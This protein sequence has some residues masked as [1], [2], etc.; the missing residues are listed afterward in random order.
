MIIETKRGELVRVA[1]PRDPWGAVTSL[2]IRTYSGQNVTPE[3]A[4]G[5]VAVMGAVS[6]V[7]DYN[8]AMPLETIDTRAKSGHKL[9]E[10]GWLAPMLRHAPN[11][12]Q[13]GPDLWVMVNAHLMLRGNAY[14]AKIRD[15]QGVIRE[16]YPIHPSCVNPYRDA[17]GRKLFRV[18]ISTGIDYTEADYTSDAI[19]HI[20]GKSINDP[21]VGESVIAHCRN[22]LGT[23]AAQVEYQARAYQD[24]MLIKGVLSTPERNL[25]PEAVERVKAQWRSTYGGIGN[26]HDIAVL[27]SG[28]QF[29]QVSLSPEDAQFIQTMRWSHTQVATMFKIPA[30]RLNGE[31]ASETY[32]N[33]GQDDLFF[34]KQACLPLRV[35]IEASLNRDPDLFG[36][37][38]PWVPRFN[39]DMALRADIETRYKV[40][41]IARQ[42]GVASQ[43]DILRAEE[44]PE[45]GPEGDD[46]TPLGG[47]TPQ[48]VSGNGSA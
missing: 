6:L 3:S 14:L 34:D 17:E 28:I 37:T 27:H 25:N 48:G 39:S 9:V 13:S 32:A 2:D 15:E 5:H 47:T 30:S 42:I 44:R 19:L 4:L 35:M 1:K 40:Y 45:I 21:L 20:K 36:A 33:Q 8:G 22:T 43:N 10:G 38:S 7:S 18:K 16:L 11:E 24:G 29:Q 31:G 46:Y 26:S 23:H 12:D 41:Q